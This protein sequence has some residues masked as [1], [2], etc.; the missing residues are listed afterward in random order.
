MFHPITNG[1]SEMSLSNTGPNMRA[2]LAANIAPMV[3]HLSAYAHANTLT[4]LF[5]DLF[6]GLDVVS[7][8][9]VGFIPGVNRSASAERAAVGQS[10]V[11]HVSG[12]AVVNDITPAMTIP[13]PADQ[14]VGNDTLSITKARAAEF[15]FTGEEQRGLNSGVGYLS[16]QGDLFAQGL[17]KLVNEVEADLAAAAAAA[18]SRAWGTAGTTPFA[19][20]LS[21]TANIRKILDD[22]GAPATGRSLVMNTT[23]GAKVRTL[24]NLTKANEAGSVMTLR[25]GAL[26]DVHGFALKESAGIINFTKGTGAGSTTNG[27]GYA[28]GATVITLAVAGTGTIKAGD[29]ITFAGDTNKYVVASGDA[30]VSNGGTITL[31]KPGLRQAIPAAA[32]A[33]TV[34]NSYAGNVGFTQNALVLAARAPA[35]PQEGDIALDRMMLTD[36]RSGLAFE[37]SLYPGYRK[38]RAEVALAWGVKA[39]KAEHIALLLG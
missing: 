4:R 10:V 31:A 25:D 23:A 33:I 20:D 34:G 13:N 28:I 16:V 35:L 8:E 30:D 27:A 11:Y 18:A 24:T 22:N 2:I 21:D 12:D 38:I 7:R 15:G 5:P 17:R 26:L 19:S 14:N 36:P 1:V 32:T 39:T 6:A 3:G 37:V 9:L 29:V